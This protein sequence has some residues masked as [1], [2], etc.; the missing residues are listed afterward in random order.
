MS[1]ATK[2]SETFTNIH[3]LQLVNER[4]HYENCEFLNC[5]LSDISHTTFI[6][7][8]FKNCNLSNCVVNNCMLQDVSFLDCKLLGIN[9]SQAKDFAFTLFCKNCNLDYASFDKK[10]LNK[11]VFDNCKMH[12]VNL[13]LADLS[14]SKLID[15]DLFEAHF[16]QTNI[17]TVDFTSSHNFTINPE[18]NQIKKAKFLMQDLEKLLYQYDIIVE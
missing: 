5:A 14:K 16:S 4:D 1:T 10:K 15:C 9:F 2:H 13:T 17:A 7:C 12:H 3:F 11:S 18:N 8:S 6:N